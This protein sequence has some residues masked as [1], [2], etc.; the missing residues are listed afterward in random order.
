[1]RYAEGQFAANSV[2]EM[3]KFTG[4]SSTA[5][6]GE[7][8]VEGLGLNAVCTQVQVLQHGGWGSSVGTPQQYGDSFIT[9]TIRRTSSQKIIVL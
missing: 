2:V 1:M 7:K 5:D 3:L 6:C 4:I 9:A 8:A